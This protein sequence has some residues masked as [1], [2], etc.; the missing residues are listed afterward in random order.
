MI[1][2]KIDAKE[3]ICFE[4]FLADIKWIIHNTKVHRS[5]KCDKN[6]SKFI[7]FFNM[8]LCNDLVNVQGDFKC[9]AF[10]RFVLI[11]L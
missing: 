7:H 5:C 10:N 6:L 11:L 8:I 4:E 9:Y 2:E 1:E 3:Y